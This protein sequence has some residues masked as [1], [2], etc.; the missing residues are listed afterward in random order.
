MMDFTLCHRMYM[1][2][3]MSSFS[4]S[5]M[6]AEMWRKVSPDL[7]P[8]SMDEAQWFA[9]GLESLKNMAPLTLVSSKKVSQLFSI[10]SL[11]MWWLFF[12]KK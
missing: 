4:M 5:G 7:M 3:G 10:D 11:V 8:L 12:L 6:V 2:H 9:H 1:F